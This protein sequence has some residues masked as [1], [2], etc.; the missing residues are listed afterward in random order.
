MKSIL[1]EIVTYSTTIGVDLVKIT[2]TDKTTHLDAI[3]ADRSVVVSSDF[4]QPIPEFE[5]IF[6]MPNLNKLSVILNIPEYKEKSVVNVVREKRD[7]KEIATEIH[8]NNEAGDFQNDYRLMGEEIIV[9]RVPTA[10]FK[11][12]NWDVTFSPEVS[13]IQKL[14]YQAQANADEKVFTV[15]TDAKNDL[16]F[17]FG[18]HSTHAGNFVFQHSVTGKLKNELAYPVEQVLNILNLSGSKTMQFSD[19]GILM[20]QIDSGISS[21]Q[22]LIPAQTK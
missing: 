7:E 14:K 10:K 3:A 19:S 5:G 17:N 13:S 2:G 4:H 8:F 22:Y 1:Q 20:I 16:K 9:N 11:G 12:A 21:Y 15:K 18:D 6:G